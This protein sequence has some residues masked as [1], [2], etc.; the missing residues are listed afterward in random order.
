MFRSSAHFLIGLIGFFLVLNCMSS[1]CILDINTLLQ[2]LCVCVYIF[3]P[4]H[5]VGCFFVLLAVS[6]AVW[7]LFFFLLLDCFILSFNGFGDELGPEESL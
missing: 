2:F 7:K 1:L 5:L 4:S 3:F 6:F